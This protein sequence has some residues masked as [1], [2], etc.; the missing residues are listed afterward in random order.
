MSNGNVLM[1]T[2]WMTFRGGERVR[3]ADVSFIP[4]VH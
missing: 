2:S 4:A 1:Y 3:I